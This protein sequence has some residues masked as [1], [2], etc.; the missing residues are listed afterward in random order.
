MAV[1]QA[2]GLELSYFL[3]TKAVPE[4]DSNCL[5]DTIGHS[6]AQNPLVTTEDGLFHSRSQE[7]TVVTGI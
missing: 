2:T 4:P 3:L 5:V 6:S 7:G 1:S